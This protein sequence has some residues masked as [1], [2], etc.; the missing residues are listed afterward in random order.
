GLFWMGEI[1]LQCELARPRYGIVTNIGYTHAERLGSIDAIAAAKREL[2]ERLPAEGTVALNADDARV[3]AMA[4]AARC[5]V[6]TYGLGPNADVRAEQIEEFGLDGLS[7]RIVAAGASVAVRT[8]LL[9]R[10]NVGNCLAA[11]VVALADG[12]TLAEIAGAL[13]TA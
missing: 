9:G 10:H 13:A 5:R 11:A 7:F 4:P 8:P 12:M 2:V 3:L 1:R 6:V